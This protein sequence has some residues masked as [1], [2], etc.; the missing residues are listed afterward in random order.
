M[1]SSRKR[2]FQYLAAQR[3]YEEATG[4]YGFYQ[5]DPYEFSECELRMEAAFR[6]WLREIDVQQ[7]PQMLPLDAALR[8]MADAW[9][10]MALTSGG[11]GPS[12]AR[13]HGAA[14]P[15]TY[16]RTA[17][18]CCA[19]AF[20]PK[21]GGITRRKKRAPHIARPVHAFCAPC[22]MKPASALR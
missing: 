6:C 17:T 5:E 20:C 7:C 15:T 19:T 13:V 4:D 14:T 18:A 11:R 3:F 8:G 9:D 12:S 21:A 16:A 10:C 1:M 22:A 2:Y